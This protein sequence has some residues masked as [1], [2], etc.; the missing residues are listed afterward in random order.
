MERGRTGDS[1]DA[2]AGVRLRRRQPRCDA[3]CGLGRALLRPR[4]C[5]QTR[6]DA[7]CRRGVRDCGRDRDAD[8]AELRRATARSVYRSVPADDARAAV[9]WAIRLEKPW[10]CPWDSCCA[11]A[12]LCDR[13]RGVESL[14]VR[15]DLES[16]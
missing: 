9:A 13:Q 5:V 11:T 4:S 12:A 3:V 6:A 14:P 7:A 1:S 15:A 8:E 16:V 2:A 10:H